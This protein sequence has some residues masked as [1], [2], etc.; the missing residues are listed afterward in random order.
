MGWKFLAYMTLFS[1]RFSSHEHR[2]FVTMLVFKA[3]NAIIE[4]V[5][6][7][8]LL[9]VSKATLLSVISRILQEELSEDPVDWI[10]NT[11]LVSTQSL[12]TNS[13][14]SV[15]VFL[16]L[17]GVTKIVLVYFLIRKMYQVYPV[18]IAIFV[19]FAVLQSISLI[20]TPTVWG[21]GLIL[22]DLAIAWLTYIEY[23]LHARNQ[24]N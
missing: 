11:L 10:A 8:L 24:V 19:S 17:H 18:A 4:I 3:L 2:V 5:A 14:L 20:H 23:R 15:I 12:S 22:I 9:V 1:E 13:K 16:F 21:G 6:G 7:T